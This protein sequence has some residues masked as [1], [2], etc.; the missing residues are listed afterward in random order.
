MNRLQTAVM[1]HVMP[2]IV[3][4]AFSFHAQAQ[5]A[6]QKVGVNTTNPQATLHIKNT[7]TAVPSLIVE[8]GSSVKL[9]AYQN[10]GTS[11]GADLTP[12]ENGLYVKGTLRP[13]SGISTPKKL[14]IESVGESITMKA[15]GSTV[16]VDK[17]GNITITAVNPASNIV[18]K[19]KGNLS[20]TGF[21]IDINAQNKLTLNSE[22][23][24]HLASK[25]QMTL[26]GGLSTIMKSVGP[27][28][29]QTSGRMDIKSGI[30]SLNG[31]GTPVAKMGGLT[32][33]DGTAGTIINGSPTVLV[34]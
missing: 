18:I 2:V 4:I 13:D 32:T 15:G 30:L 12:P 5:A 31:G 33:V 34:P 9:K 27:M 7:G 3:L 28:L 11:V 19:S 17:N 22:I 29:L 24:I 26:D 8:N 6:S 23:N 20:L 10:G 16:V 1:K 21:N 25:V 14:I